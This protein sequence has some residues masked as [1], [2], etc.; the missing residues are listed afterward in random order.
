[1]TVEPKE[2]SVLLLPDHYYYYYYEADQLDG[3]P[4]VVVGGYPTTS[5]DNANPDGEY[6]V[7]VEVHKMSMGEIKAEG[8]HFL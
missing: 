5:P 2:E 1:M 7:A 6:I 4:L 8:G 3:P